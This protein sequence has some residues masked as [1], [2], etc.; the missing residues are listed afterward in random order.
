MNELDGYKARASIGAHEE[1]YC[2]ECVEHGPSVYCLVALIWKAT[3]HEVCVECGKYLNG[4][5]E[6]DFEKENQ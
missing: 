4:Q 1:I 2:A 6:L 3:E 5:A